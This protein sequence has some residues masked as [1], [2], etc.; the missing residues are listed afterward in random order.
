MLVVFR[1]SL[2]SNP[3]NGQLGNIPVYIRVYVYVFMFIYIYMYIYFYI[4]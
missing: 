4:Y 3:K 2:L 1:I